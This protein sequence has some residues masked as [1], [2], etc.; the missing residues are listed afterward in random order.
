M[1]LYDQPPT[2]SHINDQYSS[3]HRDVLSNNSI[4]SQMAENQENLPRMQRLAQ[5]DYV[6]SRIGSQFKVEVLNKYGLTQSGYGALFNSQDSLNS[7][8]SLDRD[9]NHALSPLN[10][11]FGQDAEGLRNVKYNIQS[12]PDN[13]NDS[14]ARAEIQGRRAHVLDSVRSGGSSLRVGKSIEAAMQGPINVVSQQSS[15]NH[16]N[17]VESGNKKGAESRTET[18]RETARKGPV[19]R[20]KFDPFEKRDVTDRD[21]EYLPPDI[22][23]QVEKDNEQNLS[24][25]KKQKVWEACHFIDNMVKEREEKAK[26]KRRMYQDPDIFKDRDGEMDE[27]LGES[28]LP[29]SL[30]RHRIRKLKEFKEQISIKQNEII[31][32]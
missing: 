17:I 16:M 19:V 1:N 30:E 28:A 20:K 2:Y 9:K 7:M 14:S 11:M 13:L 5:I 24:N 21:R 8:Q 29:S 23:Q 15:S 12:H 26:E 27:V 18:I 10:L 22:L 6:M 25:E 31:K 4:A 32:I 3:R